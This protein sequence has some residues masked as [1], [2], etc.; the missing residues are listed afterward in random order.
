[1][2]SGPVSQ[3]GTSAVVPKLIVSILIELCP[4][5]LCYNIARCRGGA[6]HE[7]SREGRH[8]M[9]GRLKKIVDYVRDHSV[10]K[11]L[12]MASMRLLLNEDVTAIDE[13]TPDD[14]EREKKF[15][16]AAKI[17]LRKDHIDIDL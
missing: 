9:P 16:E 8:S 2:I 11:N 1:M 12:S 14:P 4:D 6:L 7:V 13:N 17:V 15:I 5:E 3:A 10:L